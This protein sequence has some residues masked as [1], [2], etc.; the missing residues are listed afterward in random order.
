MRLSVDGWEC[1]LP[2][3]PYRRCGVDFTRIDGIEATAALT[4]VSEVGAD[5][6]RFPG[7]K[8]FASWLGLCS[9]TTITGANVMSGKTEPCAN[10]T[11]EALRRAASA[12]RT[13]QSAIA[14][15][16]RRRCARMDN[17]KA[18]TS[19]AHKLARLI[20]AVLTK[21]GE[22]THR[23]QDDFE[24][25]CRER[26]MRQLAHRTKPFDVQLIPGLQSW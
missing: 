26:L 9:G 6:S 17:S 24:E 23:G 15:Y 4:V 2:T 21:G 1:R 12:R 25:R 22:C 19:A 8:Q 11:V 13:C 16:D 7:D 10:R 18:I 3:Q 5:R 14:A 20:C